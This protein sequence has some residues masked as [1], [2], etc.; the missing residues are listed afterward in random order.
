MASILIGVFNE[1]PRW[2]PGSI[3]NFAAYAGGYLGAGDAQFAALRLY[4]AA[5]QWN[6][7]DLGVKFKWVDKLDDAAFV[8][9]YGGPKGDVLASAF[10]PNS[11]PLNTLFVYEGGTIRPRPA[12]NPQEHLPARAWAHSRPPP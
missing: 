7:Y 10:F 6:S 2:K 5:E 9:E 11:E 12:R 3:V 8:L 4:E 1:I